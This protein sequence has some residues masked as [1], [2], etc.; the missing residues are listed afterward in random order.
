MRYRIRWFPDGRKNLH[1]AHSHGRINL[2]MT[3][4]KLPARALETA[5]KG[6]PMLGAGCIALACCLW[7]GHGAGHGLLPGACAFLAVLAL[8]FLDARK[9]A[10]S[11]PR[12][13]RSLPAE[14]DGDVAAPV[15]QPSSLAE[16]DGEDARGFLARILPEWDGNLD[17]VK[18]Q[19]EQAVDDLVTRFEHLR[20][21]ILIG[22]DQNQG[23]GSVLESIES[24]RMNLPKALSL[25]QRTSETR[26]SSVARIEELAVRMGELRRLSEAVGKIASQT[27]LLALNAAIEA[28]RSGEAGKGFSVVAAEVRELS[29]MSAKTG[30]EIR[31]MVDGITSS[32]TSTV[33]DAKTFSEE[34]QRLV[35]DIGR[36]LESTLSSLGA[37]AGVLERRNLDLREIGSST[38]K[39][40]EGVLVDLQFQD[41]T[42][43]ILTCVRGDLQRLVDA[44]DDVALLDPDD[45]ISR[46]RTGY[47]TSEQMTIGRSAAAGDATSSVT[48]F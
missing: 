15:G 11:P 13:E 40:L 45:W 32:V 31:S 29:R 38:A 41:R 25:L 17:L 19:T 21:D 39:T 18:S 5:I 37:Q 20:R 36:Q 42:S 28:A 8:S 33:T 23:S 30:A 3:E 35:E 26:T 24:A 27:N 7:A 34:E 48:F 14:Q 22:V 4:S 46:L 43:Q 2:L 6:G 16:E 1:P 47:T 12:E 44:G 9:R 10:S